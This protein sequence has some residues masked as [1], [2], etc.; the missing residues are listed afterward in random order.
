[1]NT[2]NWRKGPVQGNRNSAIELWE[3][4]ILW[5]QKGDTEGGHSE[6]REEERRQSPAHDNENLHSAYV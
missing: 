2:Q 6:P 3:T 1:M 5:P 4:V